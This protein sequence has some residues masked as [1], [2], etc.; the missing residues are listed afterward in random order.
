[1]SN[2]APLKIKMGIWANYTQF[3]T[4]LLRGDYPAPLELN[5]HKCGHWGINPP[6]TP[7][8][9][10]KKRDFCFLS[11]A[12]PCQSALFCQGFASA[13]PRATAKP[14][15]KRSAQLWQNGRIRKG[16][17]SNGIATFYKRFDFCLF[18]LA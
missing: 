12:S 7:F 9:A 13:N 14:L 3:L 10:D 1:M 18:C 6:Q 17:K 11:L 4:K 5:P 2:L 8:S 15:T 16:S